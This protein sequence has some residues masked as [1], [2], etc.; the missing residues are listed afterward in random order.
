[1]TANPVGFG[2]W[3]I[4]GPFWR[5]D[6]PV[7]WGEVDDNES[8]AAIQ[9]AFDLGVDF[10]DTADVYGAGHSERVVGRALA[11]KR[12]Q[13]LIAT[14][15]GNVFDEQSRKITGM[16]VSPDYIK[17][18]CE[19]SLRRLN[20]DHI[21]LYQLHSGIP[22]EEAEPVLDALDGLV[23]AGKIRA[24]AWSTDDAENVRVFAQRP[25]CVAVQHRL[26]IMEDAPEILAVC[27]EFNLASVNRSPLAMGL[28]T[29][30]FNKDSVLPKDDIRGNE[31]DWMTYFK[32]GKPAPE[33]I[34]RLNAVRDVL[35]SNGRTLTQGAL[36]WILAR[37]DKT[38]PI[39]G[40][41]TVAQAEENA[42]A[43]AKGPLTPD[44]MAEIDQ[45]LGRA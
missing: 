10:F 37:S 38:F 16:N 33:W 15:F 4:G 39:P 36:C 11:G 27:D 42:G 7:G 9:R 17:Q 43:M 41:R 21:D 24:Y 26:N 19:A 30:K 23:D 29:G 12:D 20:T 31:P 3:A 44:Q 6:K 32:D 45:L 13:V 34:D 5:D 40:I 14:K 18:A 8:I 1:M 2:C 25:N 28:L 22:R 35:T